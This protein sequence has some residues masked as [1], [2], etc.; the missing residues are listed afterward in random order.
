LRCCTDSKYDDVAE[1]LVS[2]A[3]EAVSVAKRRPKAHVRNEGTAVK[4]FSSHPS[5]SMQMPLQDSLKA[6]IP[7]KFHKQS[8][9]DQLVA[10]VR[11]AKRVHDEYKAN[12]STGSGSGTCPGI[13]LR[14]VHELMN[15]PMMYCNTLL[16]TLVAAKFLER[17][18]DTGRKG[19]GIL[20]S[21]LPRKARA[22]LLRQ[23]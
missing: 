11:A 8:S 23:R 7:V 14:D 4:A 22:V 17:H 21:W 1:D 13:A 6:L 19:A 15:K 20:Y 3:S 16:S 18:A 9:I 12:P 5:P 10:I 2:A